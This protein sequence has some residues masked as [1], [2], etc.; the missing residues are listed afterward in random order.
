MWCDCVHIQS[1]QDLECMTPYLTLDETRHEQRIIFWMRFR[2]SP[3]EMSE[4]V[5]TLCG[6]DV[7]LVTN[8]DL[9][10]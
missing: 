7:A 4:I 6:A 9:M 8:I 10:T 5:P 3:V 2:S 1:L